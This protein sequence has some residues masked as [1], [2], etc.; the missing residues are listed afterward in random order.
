M[1]YDTTIYT[2][3]SGLGKG[4]LGGWASV[5]YEDGND[6]KINLG[7]GEGNSAE[8]EVRAVLASL[9]YLVENT[10]SFRKAVIY[11]D[12]K[13]VALGVARWMYTW[14]HNRWMKSNGERVFARHLWE[15]MINLARILD[16]KLYVKWVRSHNGNPG[17]ELADEKAKS[18]RKQMKDGTRIIY[19]IYDL[20]AG[21]KFIFDDT[22]LEAKKV[23]HRGIYIEGDNSDE[24]IEWDWERIN[25][26]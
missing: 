22:E 20:I 3:G 18:A 23:T 4:G 12:N 15:R 13:Y 7:N 9:Q 8:L 17:N 21:D 25:I 14:E 10:K 2:D 1:N 26:L 11:T 24:L 16:K 19:N 6:P 5:I